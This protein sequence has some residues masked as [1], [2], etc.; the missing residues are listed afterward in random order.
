MIKNAVQNIAVLTAA[1]LLAASGASALEIKSGNDKVQ[2][3]VYGEL[4]RTVMYADDGQQDKIFHADNSHSESRVGFRGEVATYSCLT[5]GG[6]LE[7]KWESNPGRQ[8]SMDE[9]TIAGKF[10]P[11]FTEL[12]FDHSSAGKLSLGYGT[13]AS[14][15][16][17]EVDLSGTNLIGNAGVADLGGGLK[18]Y[19]AAAK[20]YADLTADEVFH[21]GISTVGLDEINR[22]LYE[23]PSFG[24]FNLGAS[25]GEEDKVDFSITYSGDLGGNQLEAKAAWSNPGDGVSQLNGS[26]SLLLAS[27]LNF[28]VAA[29]SKDVDEMPANGDDPSLLYGKIGQQCKLFPLG[30]TAVSVDYGLFK[31]AAVL[32]AEQ[33]ATAF[34]V[35]LVQELENYSSQLFAGYRVFSLEDNTG[36]DYEDISVISAGAR[37]TF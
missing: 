22:V 28:T 35:Q 12:Y 16:S 27:G 5:V 7:L 3:K 25:A 36:A 31:N 18:F 13:T 4:N 21:G 34:G 11:E 26:A 17:S 10:S 15:E 30:M 33:E 14:Y 2:A 6:V 9:E 32:D 1:L 23:T 29:S 8:V 20:K 24:G 19:D 37:I